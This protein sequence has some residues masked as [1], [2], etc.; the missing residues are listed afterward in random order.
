MNFLND[1]FE[2]LND[3][4]EFFVFVEFFEFLANLPMT[5]QEGSS[6]VEHLGVLESDDADDG[7]HLRLVD[8]LP[9]PEFRG[10]GRSARVGHFD[11]CSKFPKK[12]L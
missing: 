9:R 7:R 2:F 5:S 11:S 3:F 8:D 1:F 10:R 4:F 12:N 6:V